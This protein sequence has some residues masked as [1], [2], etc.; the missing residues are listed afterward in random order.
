MLP[1]PI[2]RAIRA[3]QRL[4]AGLASERVG[5]LVL[6]ASAR[7]MPLLIAVQKVAPVVAN[8]RV[9]ERFEPAIGERFLVAFHVPNRPGAVGH[10]ACVV[11]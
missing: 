3:P 7:V 9:P 5:R 8:A 2:H 4:R 11:T 1:R 6:E 10:E